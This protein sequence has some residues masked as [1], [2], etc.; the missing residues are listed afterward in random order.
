MHLGLRRLAH[1][2][3]LVLSRVAIVRIVFGYHLAI[4]CLIRCLT[5]VTTYGK[6][7]SKIYSLG[8]QAQGLGSRVRGLLWGFGLRGSGFGV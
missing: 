1:E 5:L 6:P 8:L 2:E 7:K 3:T 4:A